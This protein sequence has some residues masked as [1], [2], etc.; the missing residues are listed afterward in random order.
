MMMPPGGMPQ[1]PPQPF[2]QQVGGD[3]NKT[4]SPMMPA[5]NALAD[6]FAGASSEVQLGLDYWITKAQAELEGEAGG[7]AT[8]KL[9]Q[10][11]AEAAQRKSLEG[12]Q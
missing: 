9:Q 1:Q 2:F 10:L 11:E 12:A 7:P 8:Q 3:P 4:T 5:V 6:T